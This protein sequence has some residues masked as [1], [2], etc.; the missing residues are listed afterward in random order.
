[1]V[2]SCREL[3]NHGRNRKHNPKQETKV[4]PLLLFKITE[5][6][7]LGSKNSLRQVLLN[8]TNNV[9]LTDFLFSIS[10]FVL[11]CFMS[12]LCQFTYCIHLST[13][14]CHCSCYQELRLLVLR[15][16]GID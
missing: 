2:N 3:E 6:Y 12:E 9:C 16:I 14:D 1:M 7:Y 13:F 10:N 8:N 11:S 4:N 15:V 5:R